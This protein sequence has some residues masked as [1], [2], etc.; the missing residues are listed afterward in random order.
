[1]KKY[2]G[3]VLVLILSWWAIVPLFHSGFFPI[4]DDTQVVRV[5][6]MA[7]ALKDGQFPVRWVGDLGYGF[8]YP[9]YNF[10]APLAYYVGAIF[11]LIGFDVLMATKLMF[12]VGILLSGIF[13]Y[14]LAREF[15]GDLGGVISGLFYVYAP[16]HAV[17]VYVRGAVGEFWALA[18]LPLIFLG[19]YQLF[20]GKWWGVIVGALGFAGVILSHN[21]TAMMTIPFLF[22]LILVLI[23]FSKNKK[24]F[25]I[26]LLLFT[27]LALGISAFYWLPAL[28][29]MN[30][31]KVFGQIGG[32]ADFRDHFVYPDQLWASPWGF[33]GSAP[34]RLDGMSFM[35][36]KLHILMVVVSLFSLSRIIL[37]AFCFLLFA[38]FLTTQYSRFLW[39]FIPVMVFIQYPWRFLVFTAFAASFM[40]GAVMLWFK[41]N[42]RLSWIGGVI[43]ILALLFFNTKYF[44]PQM[45]LDVSEKD[46]I[47]EENIK[48]KTSKISDEYLPKDFPIP[49]NKNEVAWEKVAVLKG[50]AEIE[51]L[52]AKTHRYTF[53]VQARS[54]SEILINTAYFPGWKIW[55]NNK[56]T[57][58]ILDNGRIK[59]SLSAGDYQI[60][61]QFTNTPIRKIANL[62]S[63]IFWSGLGWAVF[64][65]VRT[66]FRDNR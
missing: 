6:Q 15:W 66:S 33:G 27:I 51:N 41:K 26:N 64:K 13:M 61:L 22:L 21:L 62:I 28:R 43:I 60:K 29:E 19:L 4:H 34:G 52:N 63:L 55:I 40:A 38:I 57:K 45:Y 1:M 32:G 14:F 46:Y 10:Y 48:W 39:E 44:Q 23:I 25:T 54:Q 11:N 12:L 5:Q 35:I 42:L 24:L 47:N 53:E 16:Y 3:L 59:I 30:L 37:F 31:T 50:E 65:K 20:K 56:E 18:F 17:D 49:Q 36:G 2:W 58:P 9:I 8:G 7:Q